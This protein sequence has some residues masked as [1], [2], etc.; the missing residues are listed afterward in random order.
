MSNISSMLFNFGGVDGTASFSL[1]CASLVMPDN[2]SLR[3]WKMKIWS[4]LRTCATTNSLC[5]SFVIIIVPDLI[6]D[7]HMLTHNMI[8]MSGFNTLGRINFANKVKEMNHTFITRY[9]GLCFSL[10]CWRYDG[11]VSVGEYILRF[12]VHILPAVS[13]GLQTVTHEEH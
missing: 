4:W 1:W 12:I 3:F 8:D 10:K 7:Y 2:I 11:A 9:E 5:S 13:A 6:C